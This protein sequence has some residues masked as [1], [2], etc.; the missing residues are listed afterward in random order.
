MAR[1][2]SSQTIARTISKPCTLSAKTC[3]TTCKIMSFSNHNQFLLK[4]LVLYKSFYAFK[5]SSETV[6]E[7]HTQSEQNLL[8]HFGH[9]QP[10]RPQAVTEDSSFSQLHCR[11]G[12]P[13]VGEPPPQ[14]TSLNLSSYFSV[15]TELRHSNAPMLPEHLRTPTPDPASTGTEGN[16]CS[17]TGPYSTTTTTTMP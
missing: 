8:S 5:S 7:N 14:P 2:I 15:H 10:T 16:P 4:S 6:S 3:G 1:S 12:L 9:R 17:F 11:G 13:R